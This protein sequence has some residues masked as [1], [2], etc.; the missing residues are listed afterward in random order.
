[1]GSTRK[2]KLKKKDFVKPKLKVGKSTTAANATNTEF[3]AKRITLSRTSLNSSTDDNYSRKLSLLKKSTTNVNSRQE[4]LTE[5][6]SSLQKNQDL[7]IDAILSTIRIL[8]VDQSKKVRSLARESLSLI[9][10]S[11]ENLVSLNH[12][13]LMLFLY[14]AMTHLKPTIRSDSIHILQLIFSNDNLRA[15]TLSNHW[16]RLWNNLLVLLNWKSENKSY[17]DANDFNNYTEMRVAQLSFIKSLLLQ[18]IHFNDEKLSKPSIQ[19]HDLT[20]AYLTNPPLTLFKPTTDSESTIDVNDRVRSFVEIFS[21]T[22]TA[23]INDLV[24]VD[25]KQI[26][27]AANAIIHPLSEYNTIYSNI[28]D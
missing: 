27:T 23:G 2:S 16:I 9:I 12:D 13:S 24:N 10:K 1:M 28:V 11:N 21:P 6:V 26:S 19:Q 20:H 25:N 15:L 5:I 4:I 14:S 7:P 18:G 17:V 22:V 8:F 3:K